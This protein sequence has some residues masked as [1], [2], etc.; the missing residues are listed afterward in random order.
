MHVLGA[1]E[2]VRQSLKNPMLKTILEVRTSIQK[3]LSDAL[4]EAGYVHP[5]IYM[6]SGCTDPLRHDIRAEIDRAI[7][8]DL[9]AGLGR[10]G[11]TVRRIGRRRLEAAQEVPPGLDRTSRIEGG[12]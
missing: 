3:Y 5:P 12:L 6:L 4:V 9:V 11:R 1:L 8:S 7:A 2:Q 10:F